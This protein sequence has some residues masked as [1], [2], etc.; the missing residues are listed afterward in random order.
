MKRNP[1]PEPESSA[2]LLAEVGEFVVPGFAGFT[3]T[4]FVTHVAATQ[5]EQRKPSWGKHAGAVASIG[6]LAAA[7]FLIH[8]WKWLAQYHTPLVVG[9]AIAT[10]QSLLQLYVPSVGWIVSDA[11]PELAAAHPATGDAVSQQ[12]ATAQVELLDADP[13]EFTYNDSFDAGRFSRQ[14]KR[15]RPQGGAPAPSQADDV[16]TSD[17][18]IDDVIG[19][20]NLG[21]FSGN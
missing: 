12:L 19:S 10:I 11:T 21:V 9:S 3:A 6:A 15:G 14:P 8:R 18:E 20:Q 2:P 1:G 7:W 17:M 5:I 4:R 13:N 16:D